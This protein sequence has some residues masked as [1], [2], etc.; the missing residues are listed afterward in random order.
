MKKFVHDSESQYFY[1]SFNRFIFS[2]DNKVLAKLISKIDFLRMTAEVPG[3]VVELGVFKGSGVA[4]W[5]KLNGISS[6]N[7]KKVYGFDLFS[8]VELLR[9]I[10]NSQQR[11]M[12]ESLFKDRDLNHDDQFYAYLMQQL[13]STG[14]DNFKLIK[15]DIFDTIPKFLHENP[16]F[17]ASVINCDLD[18]DEPTFFCLK[19][20]W[21]RLVVGGVVIFDEY[22]LP[23]WNESDAVD[24][25][26]YENKIKLKYTGFI[27]PS[28][29]L[30]KEF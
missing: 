7:N 20:L 14:Y 26:C 25:F 18:I 29:Y 3:D 2:F 5:L 12:M 22:A 16:G 30:M 8:D 10:K 17:R 6:S 13:S 24:R 19:N 15:G 21:P 28:A 23:E 4:A 9:S 11:D 27:C 1:D